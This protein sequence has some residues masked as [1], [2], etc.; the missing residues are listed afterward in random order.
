MTQQWKYQQEEGKKKTHI[1]LGNNLEF[2]GD[3]DV[4]LLIAGPCS[5]ESWE[6]LDEIA[7]FLVEN[8]IKIMRAGCFK[9]RTSPYK[10]QGLGSEGLRLLKEIRSKYG[11]KI[12][13][14]VKD[15]TH[16]D[17]VIE[18]ADIIQIGAKAMWDYGI[19][20]AVGQAEK[21]VL[22]KRHFGARVTEFAQCAEYVLNGG[23]PQVI[24]CERGIRSIETHT[25]FTLDLCG[26]AW[27]KKNTH[28]PIVL[29]PSHALGERYG[30]PDLTR[31]CVAMGIDGLLLEVHNNPKQAKS[32][33]DQQLSLESFGRLKRSLTPVAKA[34]GKRII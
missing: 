1:R 2:G 23:N 12:I 8:D 32:D 18:A 6:Q 10:F 25:R 20:N 7:S 9:P 17:E 30:I 11:L 24:L 33:A 29:D 22:I 28:L 19:L 34:I 31:A 27:L 3:L 4:T 14:E 13:T 21:P 5:A 15:S 26:V 16:V